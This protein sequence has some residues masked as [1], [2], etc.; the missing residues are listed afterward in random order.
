MAGPAHTADQPSR[1][2]APP[3]AG[4]PRRHNAA[5][6]AAAAAAHDPSILLGRYAAQFSPA[7]RRLLSETAASATAGGDAPLRPE[8]DTYYGQMEYHLGWRAPDLTPVA[9]HPGKLLRPTLLLLGCELAIGAAGGDIHARA[10]AV[11][12]ALPAAMAVELVHNFSLI[13]DDIEDHDE[14]RRHRP[15]LWRLWGQPQAI[16]T[17]DGMFALARLTLAG[18]LDT[19]T[20]PALVC[21][22]AA[23]LDRTC[24]HL[25]EGQHLDMSYEGRHDVTTSMY[26]AMIERKTAA[27]MACALEMGARLGG[28]EEPLAARLGACGLA[29]G[30]GFQLRDDLLGIWAASRVLGKTDDGDLRRKKMSLPVIHALEHA[31]A[32]DRAG[33]L[34]IYAAPGPASDDQI[35]AAL[36]ILARTGARARV[37]DALCDQCARARAA[38]EAAA[39]QAPGAREPRDLLGALID[40]I[41][42]EVE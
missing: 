40:F 21:R 18:L 32:D 31:S 37:R 7:L 6:R 42:A 23:L 28:A 11:T 16:N 35:A 14:A 34:A 27:L 30:L 9:A 3:H 10:A 38:L 5:P 8:L 2:G 41:A 26:L 29:L 12:R 22:L 17:G 13:H 15:T 4:G 19:G 24:L 39:A 20:D 33:L 36:A 25:C 1:R